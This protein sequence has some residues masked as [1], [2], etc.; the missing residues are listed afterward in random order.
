MRASQYAAELLP[1]HT[2]PPSCFTDRES[3]GRKHVFPQNFAGMNRRPL[4][5]LT[6]WLFFHNLTLMILY[7]INVEGIAVLPFK[8]DA[9]R[10]VDVYAISLWHTVQAVEIEARHV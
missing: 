4:Q 5:W 10:A 1:G 9:P 3:Q 7:K 6:D 2:K 8:G